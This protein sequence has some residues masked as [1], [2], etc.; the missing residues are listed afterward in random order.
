MEKNVGTF[1]ISLNIIKL[2]VWNDLPYLQYCKICFIS[3]CANCRRHYSSS[4]TLIEH[5]DFVLLLFA[6]LTMIGQCC[7][8]V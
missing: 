3:R 6:L 4:G 7:S 8:L 2:S 5:V 1:M